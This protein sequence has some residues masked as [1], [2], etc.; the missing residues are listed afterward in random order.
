MAG[1]QRVSYAEG[2]R[3][4]AVDLS[5]EQV[6]LLGLDARHNLGEHAPGVAV[7]LVAASD[8]AGDAIVTSGVAI[9]AQGRELLSSSDV[10]SPV[11][12]GA[13]CMD[14][15]IVY[16]LVPLG[17]RRPGAYD[18]S[19]GAFSRWREFGEIVASASDSASSPMP[20]YDGAVYLGRVDCP[21]TPDIGYVAL[22]GQKVADPGAHAWLQVG[23]AIGRD[24]YGFLVSAT[25]TSGV[26]APRLAVDRMGRNTFWGDVSLL[27]YQADALLPSPLTGF[28]VKVQ[29]RN[30]GDA[31]EQI[32]A[33]VTPLP[34]GAAGAA[35]ALTFLAGGKLLGKPLQLSGNVKQ[36]QKQLLDFNKTSS[37]VSLS[38]I[39][40]DPG[41][42][43]DRDVPAPPESLLTA[44]DMPLTATGGSLEL[45]KWPDPPPAQAVAVRGC[46]T[47]AGH[48]T[49][50]QLPNGIS[51]TAPDQPVKRTPLAGASAAAVTENDIPV[52]QM[53]LDLG[54][55]KDN[56]PFLRLAIGG[57]DQNGDFNPWLTGDGLGNLELCGA[58]TAATPS[59]SLN[60][61]GR[62]EQGPIQPDPTDPRFTALL[63]LAWLHGLQS[64]VQASTVVSLAFGQLPTVIETGKAW[65]Y[66]LTATN[67]G[68]VTVKADKLFETRFIAGQ[69]LLT[70][71]ANQTAIDPG[72]SQA[73]TINH[74][75]A[76]MGVTGNLSIE[77][78]M[79]GKIGNFPWW[80]AV[81]AGPIPVVPSPALDISGLPSSA[82]PGASFD[83]GFTITNSANLVIHLN[84][85]TVT[86]GGAPQQLAIAAADLQQNA[87]ETFGPVNHPGGINANVMVQIAIAFNWANGPAS[88]VTANKTI[89]SLVDLDIQVKNISHPIHSSTAWTYELVLKNTGNQPLTIPQAHGLQQRLS[90]ADFTTTPWV[91]IPLGAAITLNPGH[92]HTDAGIA[93]TQVPAATNDF[94]LQ[95]QP[96]YNRENRTWTPPPTTKDIHMP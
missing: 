41:E 77:V 61:T 32:R 90:S 27:S 31:G 34:P 56:D 42:E 22:M 57:P 48:D 89:A 6:Y 84:S 44:Q 5:S 35:L 46:L 88:S 80:K 47:Q 76:D 92:S 20:P 7:G 79:S 25:D 16:C 60:V 26:S 73:F 4:S 52:V 51:F 83:Y 12:P 81:N 10:S 85:V 8:M 43:K 91:D 82:P 63:V 53:R 23:P 28:L 18:C 50:S 78:R 36:L 67:S 66:Q 68:S 17:P 65:Q 2:Q 13:T 3:I 75:A 30:P 29:A 1:S 39:E 54:Q 87:Q 19:P 71:I 64:S 24:R 49:P 37:L 40:D 15:W 95:I 9:D 74:A 69:T 72:A 58:G 62:I 45:Q 86:E 21:A 70:N 11:A 14:L 94:Q 38:L 55:K 96:T 33:R 59:M 93:A